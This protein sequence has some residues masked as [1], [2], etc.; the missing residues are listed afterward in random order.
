M[1]SCVT[2]FSSKQNREKEWSVSMDKL[3]STDFIKEYKTMRDKIEDEVRRF[4]NGSSYN[5]KSEVS[6]VEKGYSETEK[7]FNLVL[8]KIKDDFSDKDGRKYLLKYPDRFTDS[9][10]YKLEKSYDYYLNHCV[11]QISYITSSEIAAGPFQALLAAIQVTHQL[12][13]IYQNRLLQLE[14]ISS[15]FIENQLLSNLRLSTWKDL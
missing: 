11:K 7:R 4:K 3:E 9:F 15:E 13:N 14:G 2:T 5:T 12:I 8:N 6:E 1:S 10:K